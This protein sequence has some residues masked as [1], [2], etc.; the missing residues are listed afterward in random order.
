MK[1]KSI[2]LGAMMAMT[3]STASAQ[4]IIINDLPVPESEAPSSISEYGFYANWVPVDENTG[5]AIGYYVRAYVVKTGKDNPEESKFYL[6]NTDF[7][8]LKSEGTEENPV[9]NVT[10]D[11]SFVQQPLGDPK[12]CGWQTLNQAGVDGELCLNGA[13]NFTSANAA[14]F[15]NI[16]DLRNGDGE[17][18]FKF[19]IKGDGQTKKMRVMLR[20]TDTMPNEILDMKD[21]DVTT[22]WQDIEFTLKGGVEN[23]DILFSGYEMGNQTAMYYYIDDLQ[24]WQVLK[25]NETAK[26]LYHQEFVK[27]DL[28]CYHLYIS[29]TDLDEGEDYAYTVSSYSYEGVSPESRIQYLRPEDHP[30]GINTL[31]GETENLSSDTPVIVYDMKG[32]VVSKGTVGN[33]P[34]LNERGAYIVK[35]GGNAKKIIVR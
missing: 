13:F 31:S 20:N 8:Y 3:A 28:E 12:R 7:S 32:A 21:I 14:L 27:D 9:N 33:A 24:I 2:L 11:N 29:T 5:N 19:R 4:Y 34:K 17:V 1:L 16:S 18:H 35:T 6:L 15:M 23:S 25:K 22:E 10:Q 26:A 30:T